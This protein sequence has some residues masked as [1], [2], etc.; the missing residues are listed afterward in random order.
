MK[1][2]RRKCFDFT[3]FQLPTYLFTK[4]VCLHLPGEEIRVGSVAG[5]GR[6][7]KLVGMFAEKKKA[8][9][10]CVGV[11]IGIERLFS[12]M[13]SNVAKNKSLIRTKDTEIYVA[14][15][16]KNLLEE[17]MKLCTLLWDAGIKVCISSE[18]R[19]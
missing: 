4:T 16:Q 6:Y 11:S 15:A 9:V 18:I 5:G 19:G 13:E 8:D 3:L 10:P 1:R 7:D 12:I 17:R 2:V 14:S